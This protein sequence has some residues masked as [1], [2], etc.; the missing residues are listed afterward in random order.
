[1]RKWFSFRS[2][3]ARFA[4]IFLGIWWFMHLLTFGLIMRIMSGSNLIWRQIPIDRPEY[5]FE[6]LRVRRLTGLI[7]IGSALLGTLLILLAVRGIVRPIR[8]ISRASQDIAKGRFDISLQAKGRDEISRLT[9]DFNQMARSLKGIDML[10][11][12]FV[13]N[14][15]HEFKTPITAISGYASLIRDQELSPVQRSEYAGLIVDEGR[16]LSFLS[17]NLLRLSELDSHMVK[18]QSVAYALDEQLRKSVLLME[19]QWQQKQI[20]VELDLEP[21]H[22][23]A[24]EH[25]LQEVWLNVIGNAIKYSYVGGTI[26]IKLR[27]LATCERMMVR[28]AKPDSPEP[29]VGLRLLH[30]RHADHTDQALGEWLRV[31]V[32]DEGI[33]IADADQPRIFERFFKGRSLPEMEGNGLGLVIARE[34]I[35]LCRGQIAFRSQPNAGT[36]FFID[37]PV[38]QAS[39]D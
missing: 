8:A 18:E 35:Q 37:L 16:R 4:T 26:Q 33:G 25:L 17:S 22:I 31:E 24:P 19:L 1:M 6:I 10:Q 9:E 21:L 28:Q 27:R 13:A 32:V 14:V 29:E 7:F 12:D 2:I 11:K 5:I 39:C 15:S 23:T 34:I 20:N 38:S 3:Y 36:T 30:V